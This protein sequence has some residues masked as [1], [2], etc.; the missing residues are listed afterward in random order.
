MFLTFSSTGGNS[1]KKSNVG[2]AW[3]QNVPRLVALSVCVGQGKVL[4]DNQGEMS[5]GVD[6]TDS[7]ASALNPGQELMR[8]VKAAKG[9]RRP[10]GVV[11]VEARHTAGR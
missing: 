5:Q 11:D 7:D 8:A 10:T 9:K 2:A 3:D 6:G 4:R 1:V